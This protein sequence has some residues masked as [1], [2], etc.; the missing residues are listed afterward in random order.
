M[1]T[2]TIPPEKMAEVPKELV[3]DVRRVYAFDIFNNVVARTPVDTGAARQNWIV[4]LND[5]TL[6]HTEKKENTL[7]R[8]LRAGELTIVFA[9]GDDTIFIQNNAPYIN[10]L[11]YG[12]YPKN[13]KHEGKSKLM[14][15][16]N[17]EGRLVSI[18]GGDSKTV[19]GYSRQAPNG[20]VG[21]T[22][23]KAASFFEKAVRTVRGW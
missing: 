13:P 9:K 18:T 6:E 22:L 20:M 17:K 5:Q 8:T 10:M 3:A 7:A 4:T 15:N 16:K 19:N 21:V 12:G 1:A 23:A 11:E 2:W 14:F